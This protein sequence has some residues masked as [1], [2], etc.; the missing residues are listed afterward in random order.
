MNNI[1]ELI[2]NEELGELRR[3]N[4][5]KGAAT[6]AFDWGCII[7]MLALYI[8]HPSWWTF[9]LGWV[10]VSGRHLALAITQH[11]AAH[12]VFLSNKKWNDVL[13]QWLAAGPC[14][15]NVYAYRAAH[16][17][18]HKH[19]WTEKDPDLGLAN[20][21]PIT[22]ASLWRKVWRDLSGQTGY[23]RYRAIIRISAGLRVR[24][25]GLEGKKFT[26]CV[27]AF[28][29][30]H[31]EFL[32]TNGVLLAGCTLAGRPDAF[33]LLWWLPALTGF[34]LV[35]RIRN[36]AEHAMVPDPAQELLQTRTT[37]APGWVR[38][39]MAPHHVNYHLEH[40]LY[41]WIPHYNLPRLHE[42]LRDRG[43]YENACVE[44][45]GYLKVLRLASSRATENPNPPPR[46]EIIP[47]SGG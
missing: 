26:D 32:V 41:M 2:S 42:I 19:T 15:N 27:R 25:K 16:V 30:A 36:I 31:K 11:D 18:H 1:R 33:F 35:L 4:N 21:F 13:G 9:L 38:F 7:G 34:S 40:H 14:M 3:V 43:G 8:V 29:R 28:S 45:G 37:I 44:Y 47:F 5:W 46:Q 22:R 20:K 39:L 10:V 12:G 23:K 24:N 17:Q 6:I